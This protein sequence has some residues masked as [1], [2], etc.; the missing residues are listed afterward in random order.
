MH[1]A[2]EQKSPDDYG[3]FLFFHFIGCISALESRVYWHAFLPVFDL[4]GSSVA[5]CVPCL[6][7]RCTP[8]LCLN[9]LC[10]IIISTGEDEQD[11]GMEMEND[12]EG[13]MFDVPKGEEK[14]QDAE[15][16]AEE[17]E[18]LDREMGDLGDD[19]D[20]VDMKLWDEDD[21]EDDG[22]GKEQGEEKFES[23]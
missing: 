15:D 6:P 16:D 1:F 10:C 21:E 9:L 8:Y 18:E 14:D 2:L 12:F 7:R 23:G 4:V 20:V 17:K 19:A 3:M 11:N 22:D 5:R 13:E